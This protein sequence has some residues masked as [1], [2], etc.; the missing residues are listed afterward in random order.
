MRS[1]RDKTPLNTP[2]TPIAM[3][4]QMLG[5]GFIWT[6][7]IA[8]LRYTENHKN[9]LSCPLS[10]HPKCSVPYYHFRTLWYIE[11]PGLDY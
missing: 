9:D 1:A 3:F 5:C 10:L 8:S 6:F 2:N 7:V 11:S 4:W